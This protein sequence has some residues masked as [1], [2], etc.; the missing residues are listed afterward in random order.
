MTDWRPLFVRVKEGSDEQQR[1]VIFEVREHD[2]CPVF[3]AWQ[4]PIETSF[5][6]CV[7]A[8]GAKNGRNSTRL[9]VGR[10]RSLI[11]SQYKP[12]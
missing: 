2:S 9:N 12:R 7:P 8:Q 3:A 10:S 11:C 6:Q 5:A 1:R 4:E